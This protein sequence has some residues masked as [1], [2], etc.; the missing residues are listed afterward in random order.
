MA[1]AAKTAQA[2]TVHM[3]LDKAGKSASRYATTEPDAPATNVY[4]TAAYLASVGNPETLTVTV[5]PGS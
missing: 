4:F 3:S 5:T 2:V 1:T